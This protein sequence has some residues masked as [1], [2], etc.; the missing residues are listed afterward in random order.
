MSSQ[1][2]IVP[3]VTL[4]LEQLLAAIR[5][6]DEPA[7]V[8]VAEILLATEMDSKLSALIARLAKRKPARDISDD[9]I[10]AEIYAARQSRA[11]DGN[12]TDRS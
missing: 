7:R 9:V 2:I 1:A 12:A 5:E 8:Q 4:T 3:N 11:H 6:L 10:N